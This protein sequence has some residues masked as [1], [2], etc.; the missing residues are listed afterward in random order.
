MLHGIALYNYMP[1]SNGRK[2]IL[3]GWRKAGIAGLVGWNDCVAPDDPF[4]YY[5]PSDSV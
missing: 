3:K 5:P 1:T 4:S 2:I